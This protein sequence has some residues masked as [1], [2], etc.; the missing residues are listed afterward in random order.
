MA[1]YNKEAI[2]FF[3]ENYKINK[4]ILSREVT[5]KEIEELAK[6]F[7]K[8]K[9]EVFGEGDFCRYNNG[10]CFAEHKY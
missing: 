8:M 4:F 6:E 2:R 9:F 10:L 5:L 1:V 3:I 7:P